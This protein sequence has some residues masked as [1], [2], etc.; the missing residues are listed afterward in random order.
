MKLRE[1]LVKKMTPF[2]DRIAFENSGIKY[3]DLLNFLTNN[4]DGGKLELCNGA[5]KEE[6]ALNIIRCIGKGNVAVPAS[7]IY[8]QNQYSY[9]KN[10]VDNDASDYDD[11]AFLM[12]TSGTTG[13]PK[14]VMLTD[15]NIISNIGYI[16]G[17]FNVSGCKKICIARP[18]LHIAVLTGELLFALCN[19]LTITFYEEGFMP[20]RLISFLSSSGTEIFCATPTLFILLSKYAEKYP[21]KLKVCA[22]SG[23]RLTE[24]GARIISSAFP[25]TSFYNVY[26]LT[27]HSPRVSA[28]CPSDFTRKPGSVGKPIG[29][30]EVKIEDGE[31]SVYS[32]CVMKGYFGDKEKTKQ[33]IQNGWLKTGDMAHFDDEGYLYIDGRKDNMIIRSGINIYPESIEDAAIKIFGVEDCIVLGQADDTGITKLIMKYIGSASPFEVR[34]KLAMMTDAHFMPDKIEKVDFFEKTASGKKVR[35]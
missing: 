15:E 4:P 30:V 29:G 13:K 16:S 28:L 6:Q 22:I 35:R 2:A 21:V 7:E 10:I 9:I 18:L 32:L 27:E 23:E 1:F 33:K 11:L 17:Y 24:S 25:E 19:G 12:F 8:G 31:L 20:Q 14:G 26:G 34:R 5:T 3:S